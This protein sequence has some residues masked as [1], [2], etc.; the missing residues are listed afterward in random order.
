M[1]Q[2]V[3]RRLEKKAKMKRERL[4]VT[5]THTHTAPMLD[6]VAP[7]LFGLPIPQ[8]HQAHVDRY[9]AELSDNLEKVALAALADR[10]PARLSY[11][12][13]KVNFAKKPAHGKAAPSI[14][15]CPC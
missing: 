12:V 9:T 3:A 5:A 6:G 1:T 10:K 2:E 14:M 11:G 13:G 7:T 8:E 4:A 15:I